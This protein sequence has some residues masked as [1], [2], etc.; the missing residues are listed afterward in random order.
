M[1]IIS[2]IFTLA[3]LFASFTTFA[4]TAGT[5]DDVSGKWVLSVQ[6][7]GETVDVFLELKQNGE[8]VTG[9]MTSTHASGKIDKGTYKDKKLALSVTAEMQ[10]SPAA[11]QI[12][13]AVDGDKISGSVTA[14]GLGTF[15]FSGGRSK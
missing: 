3:L 13:G 7:P 5:A 1:K 15:A 2:S 9:S 10:G 12:D 6:A 4:A 8:A 11:I 14:Q